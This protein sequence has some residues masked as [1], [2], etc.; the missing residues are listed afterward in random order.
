[1]R[2]PAN[3]YQERTMET[4]IPDPLTIEDLRRDPELILAVHARAHRMRTEARRQ[5]FAG[6]FRRF[7]AWQ[8]TRGTPV[9]Q[10]RR[11][12]AS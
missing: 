12:H 11:L 1:M 8:P 5:L 7:R 4:R 10:G 6:L 9:R 2:P 3:P